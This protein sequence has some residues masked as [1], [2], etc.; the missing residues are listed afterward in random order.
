MAGFRSLDQDEAVVS[1]DEAEEAR[2]REEARRDGKTV[3]LGV[4]R[5]Y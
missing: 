4:V 3:I 1:R 2:I 5:D